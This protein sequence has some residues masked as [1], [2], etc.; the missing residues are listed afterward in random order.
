[1]NKD[2]SWFYLAILTLAV[3]IIWTSVTVIANSRKSTITE[4]IEKAMLPLNPV[5]NRE[6]FNV[7]QGRER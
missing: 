2:K 1:M 3:A 5:I 7:L 6:M 4:D